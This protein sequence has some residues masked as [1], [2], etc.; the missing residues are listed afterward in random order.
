MSITNIRDKV[1]KQLQLIDPALRVYPYIPSNPQ[2]NTFIY[3]HYD[4]VDH[5]VSYSHTLSSFNFQLTLCTLKSATIEQA[6]SLLDEYVDST[7]SKSI[8]ANME[9]L[10][11]AILMPDA[12]H[13]HL[14]TAHDFAMYKINGT[15]YY[16]CKFTLE[17]NSV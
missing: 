17:V 1:V 3:V 5:L 4:A 12:S 16:G 13:A 2:E 10:T 9:L 6:Q 15:D 11:P 7:G 14:T 8:Q